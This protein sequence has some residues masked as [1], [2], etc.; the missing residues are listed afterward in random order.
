[1][2]RT[3]LTLLILLLLPPLLLSCGDAATS[4]QA[5]DD[6]HAT[7]D[8]STETDT[9]GPCAPACK[10]RA[11]GPDGC[12]GVCG[13]C[14]VGQTCTDGVCGHT[15]PEGCEAVGLRACVDEE[16]AWRACTEDH[17]GCL[18]WSDPIPCPAG[19][20]CEQGVCAP[21]CVPDCEG[22]ACGDDGCGGSCGDCEPPA[23]CDEG[24]CVMP[25]EPPPDPCWT[26]T[27]PIHD[28][29]L[30]AEGRLGLKPWQHHN[31]VSEP[32]EGHGYLLAGA[33]GME[34]TIT[35]TS[36]VLLRPRLF[37]ADVATASGRREGTLFADKACATVPCEL[38]YSLTL[39]YTGEYLLVVS[40][41]DPPTTG[42][43]LLTATCTE[44]CDAPF[45]RFPV[46]LLHGMAGWDSF[47]NFYEYFLNVEDD[48]L[49]LGYDVYTTKVAMFDDTEGRAAELEGQLM[50]I[51]TTTAARKLD[52][53]AHSQG[54]L[55]ARHFISVMGHASDV[56]VLAMLATPNRG[57]VVSDKVLGFVGDGLAQDV[58]VAVMDFFSNLIGGNEN[59]T[60]AALEFISVEHMVNVF[61]PS[62]PDS[63]EV[64]YWSWAGLT[65]RALDAECRAERD[66]EWVF[67]AMAIS[68]GLIADCPPGLE[69]GCGDSDGMVPYN[70]APWGQF[71][72]TVYADHMDQIGQLTTGGFDHKA[73]YRSVVEKMVEAD[74]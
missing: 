19:A 22:A 15:C 49:G 4:A 46:V 71:M 64:E 20:R 2:S 55:D 47:L 62:H 35:L 56:A 54:G 44:G 58:L 61:N 13:A 70:S 5:E 27:S 8:V 38:T 42:T 53:L 57:S 52:L 63:P 24:A 9:A 45:T 11:C 16:A 3:P 66:D 48:L 59:D 40:S 39:P 31:H 17:D 74:Y 34:V 1:M 30:E 26:D 28:W 7:D 50:D 23:S 60:E 14:E 72:G 10:G 68:Y 37:V 51:L 43:Y 41:V 73:F 12:G 21:T 6:T 65:C 32:C 36:E 33:V 29:A 25:E 67:P 18:V 69:I